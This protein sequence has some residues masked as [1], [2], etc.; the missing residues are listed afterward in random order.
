MPI[1]PIKKLR[2][3]GVGGGEGE[4]KKVCLWPNQSV[5][6]NSV[7]QLHRV[8]SENLP[9]SLRAIFSCSPSTT[10]K[11]LKVLSVGIDPTFK[12]AISFERG[13]KF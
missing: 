13:R 2:G 4:K 9:E 1:D 5:R 12:S 8:N 6:I 3:G 10:L 11:S 7:F